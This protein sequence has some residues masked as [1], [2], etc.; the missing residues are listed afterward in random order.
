M[1]YGRL[2]LA[3]LA[4]AGMGDAAEPPAGSLTVEAEEEVYTFSPANNGAGPMWCSGSTC[5]VRVGDEVFASGLE[6]IPGAK[7]LNNCRWLLFRR[8]ASGW[9][10]V[11]ADASD[12]TREPSPL[13]AFPQ[14][15]RVFLSANP[16]LVQDPNTP[17]GPARP[18]ILEFSAADPGTMRRRWLPEWRGGPKFTEHSYRS[19]AADAAAQELILFQNLDYTH[20][21]W[22][23]LDRD[24]KWSACGR[25]VW[26]WGGEYEKPQPI[27][28][29]YPNV[30][31]QG[32]SVHFCGVSD[33]VEPRSAWRE[34][35][36][37]LTGREWDYDFRRLFYTWSPD[38]TREPFRPWLEVASREATCGWISPGDLW[39]APDGM[40]HVLWIERAL[41]ERLH[42]KFFP[43]AKQRHS[44]EYAQIRDGLILTRTTLLEGGEGL[45]GKE[46]PSAGR[47]H[48]TPNGALAVLCYVGGADATGHGISENRLLELTPGGAISRVRR[49]PFRQPFTTFFTATPRAGTVPSNNLDILGQGPGDGARIRYAR[50]R[51]GTPR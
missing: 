18:E 38:V 44:L 2:L 9:T 48:P 4:W 36:R 23:F 37:E 22:S 10:R 21:E 46:I 6:T 35:K 29:C 3:I 7:P 39:V 41:D 20:A 25:L 33:I 45:A 11:A 43:D 42:P 31:L 26:P 51:L 12:R 50:V 19:F 27:R 32:R 8:D 16:T 17:A 15:G 49:L 13:A 1:A 5:I 14:T 28:I 30:A 34:F 40:V 24:G 47:F